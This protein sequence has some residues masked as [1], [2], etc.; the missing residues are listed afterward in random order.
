MTEPLSDER[1]A[2]IRADIALSTQGPPR[3]QRFE[4]WTRLADTHA[5]TLLDE[6]ERLR[7]ELA[8][9]EYVSAERGRYLA[10]VDAALDAAGQDEGGGYLAYA[11]RITEVA[12]ERDKARAELEQAREA[13]PLRPSPDHMAI[14]LDQAGC[15]WADYLTLPPGDDVLPLVWAGEQARS[16]ADLAA[17]GFELRVIG[18]SK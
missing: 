17:D 12:K 5:E 14:Y 2:K 18:W 9:E 3:Q 16:K 7:A 8:E 11:R 4:A 13:E 10:Q 15:V 1:L 6:V